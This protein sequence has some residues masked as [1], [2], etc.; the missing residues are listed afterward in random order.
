MTEY[1]GSMFV[2][3]IERPRS[4]CSAG[5]LNP[6]CEVRLVPTT[7]LA[8]GVGEIWVRGPGTMLGY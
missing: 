7:E 4:D 2:T 3:R 5:E 6:D 1:A 8:P